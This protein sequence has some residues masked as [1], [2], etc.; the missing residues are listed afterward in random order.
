MVFFKLF[1]RAVWLKFGNEK[2]NGNV[3]F[4]SLKLIK[5]LK[6]YVWTKIF[7]ENSIVDENYMTKP[8][9]FSWR[10]VVISKADAKRTQS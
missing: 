4:N 3:S 9:V 10:W 1:I 8:I 2:Y 6:S 7:L 5:L